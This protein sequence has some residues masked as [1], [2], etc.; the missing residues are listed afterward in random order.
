MN[1]TQSRFR[2]T[3]GAHRNAK[4]GAPETRWR[5][6]DTQTGRMIASGAGEDTYGLWYRLLFERPLIEAAIAEECDRAFSA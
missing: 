6:T 5:I 2:L 4:T 1:Q 3:S